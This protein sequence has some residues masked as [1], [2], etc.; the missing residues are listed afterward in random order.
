MLGFRSFAVLA[1]IVRAE[2]FEV[3]GSLTLVA[4]ASSHMREKDLVDEEG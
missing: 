4:N 1:A 2:G 3:A